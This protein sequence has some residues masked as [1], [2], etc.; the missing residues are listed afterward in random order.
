VNNGQSPPRSP[1]G[2]LGFLR[3]AWPWLVGLAILVL[4]LVR[5]PFAA[6]RDAVTRGPHHWLALFDVL[7][8]I[9]ILFT[10]AAAT[11]SGLA[12]MR[13]RRSFID[14]VVVRGAT[15]ILLVVNYAVAQGAFGYY[16]KRTG[17]TVRDAVS[18]T[19]ILMGAN[20]AAL[21]VF[22]SIAWYLDGTA[23][24]SALW[25][26]M[27]VGCAGLAGYLLVIAAAPRALVEIAWFAPLFDA[28]LRAH[29]LAI[30][31]RGPH[32]VVMVFSQWAAMRV[33]G[34]DVPVWA[35]M[36]VVPAIAFAS[37]LPISP[38]GLGTMQK[39]RVMSPMDGLLS[40]A[41][42]RCPLAVPGPG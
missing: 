38:G 39:E 24:P 41:G 36:T 19:L 17:A 16:L 40:A 22:T 29:G 25:W 5:V 32:V 3:R 21:L 23:V 13:M 20:L 14:V 28:G 12:A 33:W 6:F 15:Y 7:I 34:I 4:V 31:A 26:T 37:A 30:L 35:A 18:A 10:D 1:R 8:T 42:Q 27:T 2:L 11:W 9:I